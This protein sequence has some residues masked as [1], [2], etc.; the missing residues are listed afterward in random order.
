MMRPAAYSLNS[1]ELYTE[2]FIDKETANIKY[3][4]KVIE[5]TGI[6]QEVYSKKGNC[7]KIILRNKD[8]YNG[9]SCI[10]ENSDVQI[11]TPLKLGS[12]V[13]LKGYCEGIDSDVML[14]KCILV[15]S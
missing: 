3:K 13:T 15:R 9:V 14:L 4:S 8:I 5:V 1:E 11:I 6:V 10:I 2:Y 12:S 7:L